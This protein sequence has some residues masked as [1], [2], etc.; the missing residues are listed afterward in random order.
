MPEP[1]A[2]PIAEPCRITYTESQA[3]FERESNFHQ[4]FS[5]SAFLV[6]SDF[7]LQRC[8]ITSISQHRCLSASLRSPLLP[9]SS[10]VRA[11]P[12]TCLSVQV[13]SRSFCTS[14]IRQV[15]PQKQWRCSH[16][17]KIPTTINALGSFHSQRRCHPQPATRM[18][19]TSTHLHSFAETMPTK[20][21]VTSQRE[22]DDQPASCN[23]RSVRLAR[24]MLLTC[25]L[26]T[27]C[28]TLSSQV[29]NLPEIALLG[30]LVG[31]W[32]AVL[33][34]ASGSAQTDDMFTRLLHPTGCSRVLS[35]AL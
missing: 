15:T 7:L 10:F 23:V 3:A 34:S 6:R 2:E 24:S 11:H 27:C 8:R 32:C 19:A 9:P 29:L 5:S 13:C 21:C 25:A 16:L 14:I 30:A 33:P 17:H 12:A 1:I 31:L 22:Q 20:H 26:W 28:I 35:S 4:P 18:H